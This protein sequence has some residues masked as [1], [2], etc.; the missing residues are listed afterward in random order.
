V[1]RTRGVTQLSE[2]FSLDLP[3]SL[4]SYVK[5]LAHFLQR[6]IGVHIDPE[7]HSKNFRFSGGQPRK[8]VSGRISESLFRGRFKWRTHRGSLT[9]V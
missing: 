8:D 9:E 2:R 3:D 6:V 4:P 5:L 7:A 1:I